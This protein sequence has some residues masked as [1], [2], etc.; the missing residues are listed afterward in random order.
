MKAAG[1]RVHRGGQHEARRERERH[2]RA[3][4]A[5]RAV[6]ER[7]AQNF[8][9]V[10]GKFREFVEKEQTVVGERDFAGAR[11]DSAADQSGVGNGVV[12]RAVGAR[13]D[14]AV[15]LVEHSGDAVNL[16]GLERFFEGEGRQDGRHAFG[17]HGLAGAGRADHEDVVASGAGDLDGTLGGLLSAHVFEVD[18]ELLRLAQ[19]RVAVGLDGNDA[20]A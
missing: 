4:D 15:A 18:E 3:G 5:D 14:Q 17:Q 1:A 6:L 9:N 7:L 11:D 13:S 19:Q 2:G 20:V 10:A 8:E 12:R 16:G